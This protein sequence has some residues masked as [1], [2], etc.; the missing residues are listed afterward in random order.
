VNAE[1]INVKG[2]LGTLSAP[3]QCARRDQSEMQA[4]VRP[5]PRIRSMPMRCSGTMRALV[6]KVSTAS[7]RA[8]RR[9][10][11]AFVVGFRAAAAGSKL[12]GRSASRIQS[13]MTMPAGIKVDLPGQTEIVHQ[14]FDRQVVGTTRG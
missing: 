12:T 8:S 6:A 14:W 5:V 7:A 3:G 4:D 13:A 1:S 9:I 10:L 11:S 2:S